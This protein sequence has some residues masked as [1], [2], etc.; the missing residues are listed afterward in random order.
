[1]ELM[2]RLGDKYLCLVSCLTGLTL[3]LIVFYWLTTQVRLADQEALEKC[4]LP[5]LRHWVYKCTQPP[6]ALLC[7][8]WGIKLGA[9]SFHNKALLLALQSVL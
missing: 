6:L 5:T 7:G 8:F 1:M 3:C 9:P 2:F 4:V